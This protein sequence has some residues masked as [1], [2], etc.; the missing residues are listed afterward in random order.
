VVGSNLP[1]CVVP[2][3][4]PPAFTNNTTHN[5][6]KINI[7]IAVAGVL[8][9]PPSSFDAGFFNIGVRPTADNPGRGGT[10]FGL[11]LSFTRLAQQAGLPFTAPILSAGLPTLDSVQGSFKTP[12][13]RNVELTAPYFHNGGVLTLDQVVEFYSR[14]GNFPNNAELAAAIQPIGN[15]R[16]N[17]TRRAEVVEFLK[18]LT[19]DRVRN[20]QAPFDHPELVIHNGADPVLPAVDSTV[21]SVTLAPTGG[22][23]AAVPIVKFTMNPM[24]T[25][26][27]LTSML[28][29]G[30]VDDTAT[31]TVDVTNTTTHVTMPTAFAT[32][33]GTVAGV[34]GGAAQAPTDW[35]INLTGLTPG[36]NTITVTATSITGGI[37]TPPDPPPGTPPPLNMTILVTPTA[38]ISGTPT[39]EG[40]KLTSATLTIGGV[41]VVTYQFSVDGSVF[42]G[43]IP[44]ATPITLSGL[45]DGT[46]TV[47]VIG[48]DI[49]GNQQPPA[50]ATTDSWIVKAAPPALTVNPVPLITNKSKLT[51][52][53]TVLQGSL[54]AI[55]VDTGAKVSLVQSLIGGNSTWSC[56]FT[57]LT[58]G[59][60]NITFTASD[61]V[62]NSVSKSAA[63]TLV[64]PD[65]NFKGTGNVD[66][67]D[68]LKALRIAVGL[69]SP[70]SDDLMRGDVAPL[71]NGAPA[72]DDKI[73][74]ADAIVILK[75]V[76]GLVKF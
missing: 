39:R 70:T 53:G 59:I 63:I 13:L 52:S 45:T 31:V 34:A 15:L 55:T 61:T 72:P 2:D 1:N 10:I 74:L 6:I 65:G 38:T 54:S 75:K 35:S 47:A 46:H 42:S 8:P 43:D 36:L 44:V 29:S 76:A 7:P 71:V 21:N 60:N 73:D 25:P 4:N 3:C 50:K 18:T 69:V 22:G 64:V 68:A 26:T 49:L 62:F 11:P 40:T 19:D 48:K 28:L 14:G 9:S 30:T 56:E 17:S 5:L 41:G 16:Q 51:I 23:P 24:T 20:E 12:I 57:G 37:K 67:S 32:V 66:I 27:N 33:G 58:K